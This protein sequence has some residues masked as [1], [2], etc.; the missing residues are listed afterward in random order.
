MAQ[1]RSLPQRARDYLRYLPL[2]IGYYLGPRV[3]S[4]LRKRWVL[5]RHPHGNVRFGEGVYLGPGFSLHMPGHGTFEVGDRVEFR[6]DFR[7][8]VEGDGRIS[9][10]TES[11]FTYSV[12]M[13]CSTS[14]DV[15]DRVMFGQT[16]IVVDGQHRFRD[17]TK[18][19]LDQGYDFHPL[20]IE[21]DATITTKC[22]IMA[23][24]G[25]RAF[26]GANAV[27][28]RDIPPYTVA[29]GAPARP[30]DYFGPPGQEPAELRDG[31]ASASGQ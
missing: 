28:T 31:A 12:L 11:K 13:Q 21:D 15:G 6:R 25:T 5:A 20:T 7:A 16:T 22:T 8:E 14:I 30:I 3:M 2:K 4:E 10:G 1:Q 26:I 19:M 24:I 23:N 27:V 18:P 29:V 9:I 17:L